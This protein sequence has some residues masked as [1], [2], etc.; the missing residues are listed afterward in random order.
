V[1]VNVSEFRRLVLD[2]VHKK[3]IIFIVF[4]VLY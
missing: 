1:T 4:F 2:R 3:V